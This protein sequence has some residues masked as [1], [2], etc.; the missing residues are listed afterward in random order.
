[1]LNGLGQ[2]TAPLNRSRRHA[3]S[4]RV[5]SSRAGQ[6]PRRPVGKPQAQS[7]GPIGFA[8]PTKRLLIPGYHMAMAAGAVVDLQKTI[9]WSEWAK[10]PYPLYRYLRDE[11]PVYF[12]KRSGTYLVTRYEDVVAVLRDHTRFS[13][14][15]SAQL[16]GEREQLSPLREEDPPC[17]TFRRRL[18]APLFASGRLRRQEAY[19]RQ[20]AREILDAAETQNEIDASAAIAV[21]L[22]GRVTCDLLGVPLE[23]HSRF[24]ALTEER[25]QLLHVND[26]RRYAA[27]GARTIEEV[28]A[29]LWELVAPVI[30]ERRRRPRDDAISLLVAAR[31]DGRDEHCPVHEEITD[32]LFINMLLHLLTGGFETTQHLVEMLISLYA[33][34][35]DLW[36]RLRADRTLIDRAIEE[37]LRWE[38]PVQTVRRRATEQMMLRDVQI[39]KD[40]TIIAV[41]GSANRDERVFDHPDLYDLDREVGRYLAFGLGIHYCPGA[42]V[43]RLEVHALLDE[44]LDRYAAIERTGPSEPLPQPAEK[45]TIEMMRGFR[46][47]PVRL[48]RG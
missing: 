47:V 43:S 8:K 11:R 41:L 21:R 7:A 39:P 10:D 14:R 32:A 9:R 2:S 4:A 36:S 31:D 12:D 3:R 34:R 15:P 28:R 18:V 35:P 48:R 25:L 29:D 24:K 38:A 13:N 33:D 1:M 16:T 44:M 42:P 5:L 40:A 27:D 20:V 19:F 46:R 37:M 23:H 30:A 22:P 26:G 6:Q 45:P 17:H